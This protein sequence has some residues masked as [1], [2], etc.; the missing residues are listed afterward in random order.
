MRKVRSVRHT[1]S[2]TRSW[3]QLPSHCLKIPRTFI[4]SRA[5]SSF[6]WPWACPALFAILFG[7]RR[8][9]FY[10]SFLSHLT[11]SCWTEICVDLVKASPSLLY[12]YLWDLFPIWI[13]FLLVCLV[14]RLKFFPQ[15]RLSN[16]FFPFWWRPWLNAFSKEFHL[17]SMKNPFLKS[18]S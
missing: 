14:L 16:S 6:L 8:L 17:W 3:N 13:S 7:I 9:V 4:E 12:R 10:L 1:L 18:A 15:P 5:Q 2:F 11:Y